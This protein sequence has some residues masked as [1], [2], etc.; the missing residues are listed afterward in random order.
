MGFPTAKVASVLVKNCRRE[1]WLTRNLR[2][3]G[4]NKFMVLLVNLASAIRRVSCFVLAGRSARHTQLEA[5]RLFCA[6]SPVGRRLRRCGR[7]PYWPL[8]CAR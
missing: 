6:V 8:R 1:S 4:E 5:R 2:N 7:I 3:W